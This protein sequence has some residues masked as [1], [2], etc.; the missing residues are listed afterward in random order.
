[1]NKIIRELNGFDKNNIY[2]TDID[3]LY[4]DKKHWDVLDK[5]KLVRKR[6]CQGKEGYKTGGIFYVLFLAPKTKY[7]LT[8]N[9]YGIIQEHKTF[10]GFTDSKRLL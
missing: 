8:I 6:L 3:S 1:M 2:Y 4:I 10:K 7:C 5:A 9:D